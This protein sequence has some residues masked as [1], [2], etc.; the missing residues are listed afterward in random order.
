V[1]YAKSYEADQNNPN[2]LSF[3]FPKIKD[4]GIQVPDTMIF[5]LPMDAYTALFD[6]E[7]SGDLSHVRSFL[8]K[9]VIP[10]MQGRRHFMKNGCFS[11]K[12]DFKHCIT[13]PATIYTDFVNISSASMSMGMFG[14]GGMNELILRSIIPHDPRRVPTI[15]QGMPLRTE[16]RVFYDFDAGEVMYS[17]N[18]WD[19]DTVYPK[20]R[21]LTDRI[22]FDHMR[23]EIETGYQTHVKPVEAMLTEHLAK[24]DLTGKWSVD[25]LVD[26]NG[27]YWLIDMAEGNRSEYWKFESPMI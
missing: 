13:N 14:T 7:E 27:K 24:V 17:V 22:V 12:F 19:Y 3:W 15:Y 21:D 1:K 5:A 9:E 8:D 23:N 11:N 16:I 20:L 10:K 26:G 2:T 18:Y 4:C 6:I 25:I